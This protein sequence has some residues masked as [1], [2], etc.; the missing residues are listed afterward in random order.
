MIPLLEIYCF[1]DDFCKDFDQKSDKYFLANPNRKRNRACMMSL[2][3]IMTILV[4][5]QMSHYKTFKD[6]YT[7]CIMENYRKEFPRL[8][9]YNR[10]LEL[11]ASSFM[12]M[13]VLLL[14]LKGKET[15]KYYVDSTKL[16]VCH[17]F[18]IKRNKVF[19]NCAERGKT[20][21]GWFFGFKLHIIINDKGEIM[22]FTMT[23]GNVHDIKVVETLTQTLKGWLFGDRGYISK[24]LNE[25]LKKRGLELFT[26]LKQNMKQKILEPI[27]KHY[28][29]QRNIVETIIGQLKNIMTIDHT[30]HRSIINFQVNVLG[31][32]IAY[33]FKPKKI[34]TAFKKLNNIMLTSS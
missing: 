30:R 9:S 8:V 33:S 5:F 26:T 21:T 20:S 12:P 3:E 18:R 6:F 11:M 14:S 13:M 7:T 22:N 28:L 29:K 31:G 25:S 2:S 32:L 16:P 23:P 34:T 1:I 19:K 15:G 27:Q 24:N 4:M 10:F 17:N